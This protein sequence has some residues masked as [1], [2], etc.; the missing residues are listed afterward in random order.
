[1]LSF[2]ISMNL[3]IFENPSTFFWRLWKYRF[4]KKNRGYNR[5]SSITRKILVCDMESCH[6]NLSKIR[7]IMLIVQ[8]IQTFFQKRKK[9][10]KNLYG[11]WKIS[12]FICNKK[13]DYLWDNCLFSKFF[14]NFSALLFLCKI[15]FLHL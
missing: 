8:K 1:M 15:C 12:K 6:K 10:S 9:K 5:V 11:F 14:N 7:N 13:R 2:F 3:L 4:W